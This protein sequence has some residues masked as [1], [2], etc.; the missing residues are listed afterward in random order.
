MGDE[1][2]LEDWRLFITEK[3]RLMEGS[4]HV[5]K[6]HHRRKL[7]G[8]NEALLSNSKTLLL[9]SDRTGDDIGK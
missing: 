3:R 5:Y 8:R 9:L 2:R 6:T 7:K 4:Y 1:E